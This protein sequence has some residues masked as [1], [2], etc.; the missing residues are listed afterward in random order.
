ML[1]KFLEKLLAKQAFR[2]FLTI[3]GWLLIAFVVYHFS[4]NIDGVADAAFGF[5]ILAD[6]T[7]ESFQGLQRFSWSIFAFF[8]LLYIYSIFFSYILI[9]FG[10][11]YKKSIPLKY[12]KPS[13]VWNFIFDTPVTLFLWML[14]IGS[15]GDSFEFSANYKIFL[16]TILLS[17]ITIATFS[18]LY[19]LLFRK[20]IN[21]NNNRISRTIRSIFILGAFSCVGIYLLNVIFVV[22]EW[23][24]VQ[25]SYLFNE[26]TLLLII[27][28]IIF[29]DSQKEIKKEHKKYE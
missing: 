26:L 1:E 10:T 4:A 20:R 23:G 16:Y 13:R 12:Q 24:N 8:L 22:F 2:S 14:V 25:F 18:Y 7:D 11:Q 28:L 29:Y 15:I 27:F 19:F 9:F 5:L 17:L 21:E 3:T 6:G